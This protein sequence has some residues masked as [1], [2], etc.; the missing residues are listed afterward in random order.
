MF[1]ILNDYV[2][3]IVLNTYL[4]EE[5]QDLITSLQLK[6]SLHHYETIIYIE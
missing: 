2:E 1:D 6:V 4:F 5:L 3:E